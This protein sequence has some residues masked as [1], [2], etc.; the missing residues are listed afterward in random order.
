MTAPQMV[1]VVDDDAGVRD[2]LAFLFESA[3]LP[4]ATYESATVLLD[5]APRLMPGCILTDIRMPDL[6]GMALQQRLNEIGVRLPVIIMTGHADVPLAV[7]ALKA[8]AIDFIEKPFD[9]EAMLSAVRRALAAQELEG[10]RHAAAK[11]TRRRIASL[12]PRERE[13]MEGMIL[14]QATKVIANEL[15]SSPRTVEV[16]RARVMEKMEV[17]SLPELV[18]KVLAAR[19]G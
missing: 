1:H 2:S 7:A 17:K 4:V 10:A 6:D 12:T 15:G 13:V 3:G 11:E 18:R 19:E 5:A 8:G 16:H 9:D 14:G